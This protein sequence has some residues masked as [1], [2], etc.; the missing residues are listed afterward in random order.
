MTKPSTNRSSRLRAVISAC[1]RA[2]SW[3]RVRKPT[4]PKPTVPLPAANRRQRRAAN[5]RQRRRAFSAPVAATVAGGVLSL[6]AAAFAVLS[7]PAPGAPVAG[8]Q[9]EVRFDDV[10]DVPYG[11]PHRPAILGLGFEGMFRGTL[12]EPSGFC[13]EEPLLRRDLAVW[14]ARVLVMW[15]GGG[16]DDD[17]EPAAATRFADVNAGGRWTPHARWLLEAGV[18]RGCSAKPLRFCGDETVSRAQMASF[19]VRL[20]SLPS[21]EPAGFDDVPAGSTHAANIDALAASGVTRGCSEAPRLFCPGRATTRGQMASFIDRALRA[22][23]EAARGAQFVDVASGGSNSCGLRRNGG[24]VCWGYAGHG[25]NDVPP[26]RYGDVSVGRQHACAVLLDGPVV[27]WGATKG[28]GTPPSGDFAQVDVSDAL[29]CALRTDGRAACWGV[30]TGVGATEPPRGRFT[31]VS[32]GNL[33]A[34]GLRPS[35]EIECWGNPGF[36]IT[37][38]PAGRFVSVS[39]GWQITCAVRA[40]GGVECWGALSQPGWSN[41]CPYEYCAP[42]RELRDVPPG[43]FTSIDL[44]ASPGEMACG[45]VDGLSECW[46]NSDGAAALQPANRR[47]SIVSRGYAYACGLRDHQELEGVI[48]CWGVNELGQTDA[49]L[50]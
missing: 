38:A 33:H 5:R 43:R 36:G 6:A 23:L 21:A 46:G 29:T 9:T 16:L 37:D 15:D 40:G 2:A 4:V 48:E 39:A 26:G 22:R 17:P 24:L 14:A 41:A 50:P 12:C 3:R 18:T 32:A 11:H 7:W 34:C 10:D 20:F 1:R 31:S 13:P 8:A 30:P 44:H 47:F 28:R 45:I 27:C 49:P 19:L 42:V 35:R 25:I